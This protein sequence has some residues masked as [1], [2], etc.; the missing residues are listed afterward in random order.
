MRQNHI[1][2]QS[3]LFVIWHSFWLAIAY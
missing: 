1:E 3:C 2:P